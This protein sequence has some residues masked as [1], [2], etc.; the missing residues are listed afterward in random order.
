MKPTNAEGEA[1]LTRR[2]L[3]AWYAGGYRTLASARIAGLRA[4]SD[5]A[6]AILIRSTTDLEPWL[7][8]HF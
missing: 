3:A 2:Q 7:P 1:A 6:L 4:T 5:K 8:D